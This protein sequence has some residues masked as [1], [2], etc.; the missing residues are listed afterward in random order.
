MVDEVPTDLCEIMGRHGSDK[1]HKDILQCKHNYTQQYH[2]LFRGMRDQAIRVFELGL[3]T[4]N[5]YLPSSMGVN[6]VPGASLRG[7]KEYFPRAQVFGADID[8]D[9]LFSEDRIRTFYCDQ[10]DP[11][12]ILNMW[13]EPALEQS[14]DIIVE[15]GLHEFNANVCFF[16]NSFYKVKIGGY[17]IVEDVIVDTLD[18]WAAKLSEW[19]VR[20]PMF[21]YTV[22][23]LPNRINSYDNTLIVI[24][25]KR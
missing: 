16:E 9:I 5:P 18:A 4:N 22:V 25:R 15:D 3:G 13:N 11:T 24:R 14:F 20:F 6:G 17:F 1:G 7:W 10:T 19:R 2:K 23:N 8:R 21:E 12:V